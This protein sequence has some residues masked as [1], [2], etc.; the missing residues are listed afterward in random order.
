M[1]ISMIISPVSKHF[2]L[3]SFPNCRGQQPYI[4]WRNQL[5]ININN[6]IKMLFTAS[7]F[8]LQWGC[9]FWCGFCRFVHRRFT[10]AFHMNLSPVV[11]L[12]L[13][14]SKYDFINVSIHRLFFIMIILNSNRNCFITQKWNTEKANRKQQQ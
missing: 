9:Y 8:I 11:E 10:H 6:M 2:V 4:R 7:Y 5:E 12:F 1:N 13:V 14:A 3:N